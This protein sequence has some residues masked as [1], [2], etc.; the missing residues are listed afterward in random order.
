MDNHLEVVVNFVGEPDAFVGRV[1]R[2]FAAYALSKPPLMRHT[3][4]M[5]EIVDGGLS[6]GSL[7][8]HHQ[9]FYLFV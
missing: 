2:L 4:S 5:V 8:F 1:V 6:F 7:V 9:F 3:C